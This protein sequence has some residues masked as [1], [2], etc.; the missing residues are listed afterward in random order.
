[1]KID[2]DVDIDFA[3]REQLLNLIKHVPAAMRKV[4]PMR[5]HSTGVHITEVPYDPVNDMAAI[6]YKEAE[7]R[8]YFKLDLLNVH[9]YSKVR[10]EAHL[11]ELMREPDWSMLADRKTVEKLIHLNSQFDIMQRMPEPVNS[12]PRLAM[13]LAV[14]RPAKRHLIGKSWAEVSKSVWTKDDSGYSFKKSHAVAYSHLVVVHMNILKE[15][16]NATNV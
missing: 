6:D 8:G 11:I 13:L 4:S 5:K 15:E 12:I 9:V 3:D 10:N 1:M 2:A 7:Q 14:I 16:E